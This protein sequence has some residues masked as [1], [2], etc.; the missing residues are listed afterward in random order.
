MYR[1]ICTLQGD[2]DSFWIGLVRPYMGEIHVHQ[3]GADSFG[4]GLIRPHVVEI[5]DSFY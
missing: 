5:F 1:R 3:G 4:I 2:G